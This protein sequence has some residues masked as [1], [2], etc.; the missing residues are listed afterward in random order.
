MQLPVYAD[1]P[2]VKPVTAPDTVDMDVL[3][4]VNANLHMQGN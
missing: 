2:G 4:S 1:Y 3:L